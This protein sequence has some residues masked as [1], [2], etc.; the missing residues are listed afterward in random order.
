MVKFISKLIKLA[1]VI[2]CLFA[3]ISAESHRSRHHSH[4]LSQTVTNKSPSLVVHNSSSVVVSCKACKDPSQTELERLLQHYQIM[5][6]MNQSE[7]HRQYPS[8][9]LDESIFLPKKLFIDNKLCNR[10][11]ENVT[12][13]NQMALCPWTPFTTHNATR[14]P[15][16]AIQMKCRCSECTTNR[17]KKLFKNSN[18][19]SY[20]YQCQPVYKPTLFLRR[21][22]KQCNYTTT[23]GGVHEWHPVLEPVSVACVCAIKS[24]DLLNSF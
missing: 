21:S 1:L 13:L 16:Q 14:Y 11:N 8:A 5:Y 23:G 4:K 18:T 2:T 10:Q 17:E 22:S 12:T 20:L 15:S 3:C 6:R 24:F 7:F 9:L 19:N